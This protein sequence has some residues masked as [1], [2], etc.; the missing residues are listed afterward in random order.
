VGAILYILL[1][2][3]TEFDRRSLEIPNGTII[4][5][6]IF[7]ILLLTLNFY[8]IDNKLAIE[9]LKSHLIASLSIF[10][11]TLILNITGECLTG[12]TLLGIGDSKLLSMGGLWIGIK[13]IYSA[14]G[15][16]F[17]IAGVYSLISR[18]SGRL[19]LFDVIPFAPFINGGIW[20]VWLV[21]PNFVWQKLQTLFGALMV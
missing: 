19:K 17:L 7:G 9:T 10:L 1:A 6:F 14:L 13:G 5:G 2:Y 4:L 18:L 8:F 15:L 20:I 11:I 21:G 16:A 12:V 3:I